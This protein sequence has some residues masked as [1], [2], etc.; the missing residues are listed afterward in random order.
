MRA[1]P[2]RAAVSSYAPRGA[3]LRNRAPRSG[4]FN[5]HEWKAVTLGA[6]LVTV[7]AG[8]IAPRA[9]EIFTRRLAE[10]SGEWWLGA[11]GA[12]FV[13][14][15]GVALLVHGL[16]S[17]RRA[18]RIQR[19]R[20]GNPNQSWTW[21]YDWDTR[22]A[23]DDDTAR[24]ARLFIGIGV[25]L[26]LLLAPWHFIAPSL[27]QGLGRWAV[28]PTVLFGLV[29]LLF[30]LVA[31]A[32]AAKGVGL[33]L[34]RIKYG[35][36]TATFARFPFRT[37]EELEL[38]VRA[39]RSLPQHSVVTARL[40]CIQERYVTT[41]RRDGETDT[42]VQCYELYRDTTTAEQIASSIEA[43]ALRVRFTIPADA[44]TTDLASRPCRYWEV[45]VEAVTDGV[46]YGAR[47]LVPV[48]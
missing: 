20:A 48:Y 28:L 1:T 46:D 44:P 19:R 31:V 14:L 8:V 24:R 7:V 3:E 43:R 35:Q 32:V 10:W 25:G 37:G 4:S 15:T 29:V 5:V 30:D 23:R 45:D 18:A 17:I 40:R 34:R 38:H 22:G 41:K 47:F 33:V 11:Y 26:G 42:R 9:D 36:G 16:R 12:A 13:G 39:P 27:V 2:T 6:L 21:D